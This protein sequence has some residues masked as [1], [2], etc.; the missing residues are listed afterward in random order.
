MIGVQ[1]EMVV[2]IVVIDLLGED[3]A[4][5]VSDLAETY[6]RMSQEGRVV[7]AIGQNLAKWILVPS[8]A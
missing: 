4:S 5:Q 8:D 2:S 1:F 6:N 3:A 7:E